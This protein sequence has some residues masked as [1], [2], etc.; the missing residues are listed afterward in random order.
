M[1]SW[2]LL[3]SPTKIIDKVKAALQADMSGAEWE[4]LEEKEWDERLE[5]EGEGGGVTE[6][7]ILVGGG[8]SGR[9]V[10]D[11]EGND[12]ESVVSGTTAAG[13][14]L[15]ERGDSAGDGRPRGTSGWTKVKSRGA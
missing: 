5:G 12:T 6:E 11:G 13:L 15:E 2:K 4:M 1:R 7:P 14:A 9:S 8:G 3:Q 10:K